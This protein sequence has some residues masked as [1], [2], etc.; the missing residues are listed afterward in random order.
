MSNAD[1]GLVI[2]LKHDGRLLC[3]PWWLQPLTARSGPA[4]RCTRPRCS[5]RCR[6]RGGEAR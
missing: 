4:R 6:H 3:D 5:V 1:S 2:V